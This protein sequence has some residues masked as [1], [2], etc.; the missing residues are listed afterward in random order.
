MRRRTGFTLIELLVVIAVIALLIGLL[1]PALANAR[2]SVRR[3]QCASNLHQLGVAYVN[4]ASDSKDILVNG[5][6]LNSDSW[7]LAGNIKL[8]IEN[9]Q[10]FKHLRTIK[11]Y[12]CPED[13]SRHLRSYSINWYLNGEAGRNSPPEPQWVKRYTDI[14]RPSKT[15]VYVEEMDLRGSSGGGLGDVTSYNMGSWMLRLNATNWTDPLAVFHGTG[16]N[17]GFADGHASWRRWYDPNT[18]TGG[19]TGQIGTSVGNAYDIQYVQSILDP[20]K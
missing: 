19:Q 15:M 20:T 3:I 10:I 13:P 9:G 18:I 8:N 17:F 14:R 16:S 1:L 11:V 2:H 5:D 4:Y 7:V 6:V 12:R